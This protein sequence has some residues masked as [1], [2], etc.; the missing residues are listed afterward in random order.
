MERSTNRRCYLD[1]NNIE[2]SKYGADLEDLMNSSFLPWESDAG[3]SG[4]KS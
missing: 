4:S 2:I 3:A 1:D